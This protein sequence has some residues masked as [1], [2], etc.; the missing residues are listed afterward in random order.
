MRLSDTTLLVV[1]CCV[2]VVGLVALACCLRFTQLPLSSLQVVD[3]AHDG[4]T[5]RVRGRVLAVR[6][7]DAVTFLTLAET[8]RRPAVAFTPLTV[9]QGAEVE[10]VGAVAEYEGEPELI[11]E[12]LTVL[13]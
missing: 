2:A 4:E 12:S 9:T 11:V 13:T 6:A 7:T 3:A 8:V 1:A 10:L 5:V